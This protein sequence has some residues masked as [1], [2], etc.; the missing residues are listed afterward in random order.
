MIRIKMLCCLFLLSIVSQFGPVSVANAQEESAYARSFMI[1]MRDSVLLAADIY[2]PKESGRRATILVRT[3]FARSRYAAPARF[4]AARDYNVIVQSIRGR[5]GSEGTDSLFHADSWGALQDGYDSIE[6]IAS[7]PWS[8]GK[9]GTFGH[10]VDG[11]LQYLLATTAPPHLKAQYIVSAPYNFYPDVAF[12][13]GAFRK[14]LMQSWLPDSTAAEFIEACVQHP[15]YGAFWKPLTPLIGAKLVQVPVTHVTGWYDVFADAAVNAF[16]SI[17]R[18]APKF[19]SENQR[20]IIGPWTHQRERI[21]AP[22][23]GELQFPE[24]ARF[25]VLE[26]AARWFDQWLKAQDSGVLIESPVRY[27]LMGAPG[28]TYAPGNLWQHAATWPPKF[29]KEKYFLLKNGGIAPGKPDREGS[30]EGFHYDPQFPLRTLGGA[31]AADSAGPMDQRPVEMRSDVL[32]FTSEILDSALAVAGPVRFKLFGSST[33]YDTDFV[34]KLTDVYPDG[35]SIIVLDG[36]VRARQRDSISKE[37]LL[38]P[39]RI[40][41]FWIELGHTALVFNKGHRIRLAI[42]SSN[43]PK[44]EPNPNSANSFRRHKRQRVAVNTVYYGGKHASYLELPVIPLPEQDQ[45]VR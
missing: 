24:N 14:R 39:G 5:N 45:Y 21:G 16:R 19:A 20:L 22:Q 23:Q 36:I 33:R 3:P 41:T 8:D 42:S 44:Y 26:D 43:S 7:Q 17:S 12:R 15:V 11:F 2:L 28:E 18:K 32:L 30:A 31:T 6:W 29:R 37:K 38:K 40:E 9:V 10:A 27:Y 35:R 34:V 4:F 13:Q 25:N 1:M